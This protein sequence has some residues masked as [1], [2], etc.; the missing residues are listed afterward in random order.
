M[1]QDEM[2]HGPWGAL[3]VVQARPAD[4]DDALAID[5]S[6]YEW[7]TSIGFPGGVAPRPLSELFAASIGRHEMYLARRDDRP[8]G[9]LSLQWE[10]A[11]WQD[12]PG[13]AGY[14]H[15]LA[16]HRDFAGQGIGLAL[17]EWAER[18]VAAAGG[19]YLRLD[20]DAENP[21]LRAYYE[22]AGFTHRGNVALPHRIASRY[23]KR[24]EVK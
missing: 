20:C 24:I 16:T 1:S 19:E 3:R 13:K 6:A 10:D 12:V 15:G 7:R 9:K 14:V 11:L 22:R 21:K 17:L 5:T 18:K 23:E 8:A 4:L 2:I